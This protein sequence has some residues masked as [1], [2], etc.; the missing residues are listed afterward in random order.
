MHSFFSMQALATYKAWGMDAVASGMSVTVFAETVQA[1][2]TNGKGSTVFP[3]DVI[4]LGGASHRFPSPSPLP[5][6][7]ALD[8]AKLSLQHLYISQPDA[9]FYVLVH[10]DTYVH[11]GEHMLAVQSAN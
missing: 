7:S 9:K 5:T 8:M 6:L 2:P 1:P 10:P 3:F 11:L 4:G